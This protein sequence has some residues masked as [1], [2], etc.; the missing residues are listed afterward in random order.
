[1]FIKLDKADVYNITGRNGR[2][3][4]MGDV[5][6]NVKDI[7]HI[8]GNVVIVG[9]YIFSCTDKAIEKISSVIVEVMSNG[10]Q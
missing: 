3:E 9:E 7:S 8:D 5:Y 4:P 1:M 6:I 2:D 10:L